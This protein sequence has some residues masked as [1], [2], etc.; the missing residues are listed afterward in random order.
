MLML[1]GLT[2][3]PAEALLPLARSWLSPPKMDVE[4][5]AFRGDGFD[6]T[7]RAFVVARRGQDG[8]GRVTVILQATKDSPAVNPVLRVRRWGAAL[9]RIEIGGRPAP[10]GKDV[11]AGLIPGLEGDDL[12]LWVRG[13]WTSPLRISILTS[14]AAAKGE[15]R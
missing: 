2:D 7:E 1:N 11:R 13:E 5:E 15:V 8:P 9:P 10:L 4:G 12:V 3:K 14:E 6:P